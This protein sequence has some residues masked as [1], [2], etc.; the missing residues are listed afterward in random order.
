MLW[1][2]YVHHRLLFD[3]RYASFCDI[4][5]TVSCS[6]VLLSRYSMAYGVPVAIFGAIWF[7]GILVLLGAGTWGGTASVKTFPGTCLRF[8]RQDWL[9]CCIWRTSPSPC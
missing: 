4:N 9:S 5:S 7:A 6:E 1:A 8:P 2:A 3:P